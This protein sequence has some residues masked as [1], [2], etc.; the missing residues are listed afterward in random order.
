MTAL[1]TA[2]IASLVVLV[3]ISSPA[4]ASKKGKRLLAGAAAVAVVAS[5]PLGK[6]KS[7]KPP[8]NPTH[9]L[10]SSTGN[11]A[12]PAPGAFLCFAEAK[13]EQNLYG[14][15]RAGA[16]FHH[17]GVIYFVPMWNYGRGGNLL[18]A[19]F[20]IYPASQTDS[21]LVRSGEKMDENHGDLWD[22]W[23]SKKWKWA[24]HA[25]MVEALPQYKTPQ[26]LAAEKRDADLKAGKILSGPNNSAEWAKRAQR[27][28]VTLEQ[29]YPAYSNLW[30]AY[31]IFL[32]RV[33]DT[34]QLPNISNAPFQDYC[35]NNLDRANKAMIDQMSK[36]Y[37]FQLCG[38]ASENWY[39]MLSWYH[40]A[41]KDFRQVSD[42]SHFG[43]YREP[44]KLI[45]S[46]KDAL[47]DWYLGD[48]LITRSYHYLYQFAERANMRVA[49]IVTGDGKKYASAGT[50]DSFYNKASSEIEERLFDSVSNQRDIDTNIRT[51]G[52]YPELLAFFA[53]TL[54]DRA[55]YADVITAYE[56]E[57]S[58]F[59]M[60]TAAEREYKY[61]FGAKL[62][63]EA[64]YQTRGFFTYRKY[65]EKEEVHAATTKWKGY[66]SR[67]TLPKKDRKAAE[68]DVLEEYRSTLSYLEEEGTLEFNDETREFCREN[69]LMLAFMPDTSSIGETS[70][71]PT[72]AKSAC[73]I[74]RNE[75]AEARTMQ[76][77]ELAKAK[78]EVV[79]DS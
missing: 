69:Y 55:L 17:Q 51:W 32:D 26:Q 46:Q 62:I 14:A 28:F 64:C 36:D 27:G 47:A 33:R 29:K 42:W 15:D 48:S 76:E 1:R 43:Y 60:E 58:E 54:S 3:A 39:N 19:R 18:P 77:L 66:A 70:F 25:Q 35:T 34:Q 7:Y 30:P 45:F 11:L 16:V 65:L 41:L 68:Q 38:P 73:E 9:L 2:L 78:V 37:S 44:Q 12:A 21:G 8:A 6:K 67:S 75:V 61:Y 20:Q 74:A 57:L 50:F 63:V 4:S 10:E 53:A 56:D 59:S 22:C 13:A 72:A 52:L 49:G 5:D 24:D 40:P 23:S 79:C 31:G 71:T